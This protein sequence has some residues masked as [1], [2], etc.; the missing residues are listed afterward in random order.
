MT[1]VPLRRL[2]GEP[3]AAYA[4][5]EYKEYHE[6][7][8]SIFATLDVRPEIAVECNGAT[9]LLAA[10]ESGRGVG[11]SARGL[12]QLGGLTCETAPD[13]TDTAADD[14][15]LCLHNFKRIYCRDT[16]F[17]H[18]RSHRCG[19]SGGVACLDSG[20]ERFV[21][22]EMNSKAGPQ[23]GSQ[24]ALAPRRR[25]GGPTAGNAKVMPRPFPSLNRRTKINRN[26]LIKS[27][28]FIVCR[29]LSSTGQNSG[30]SCAMQG[31]N[32]RLPA[33]EAGALP[34]S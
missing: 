9:S 12:P 31:S 8:E 6:M 13:R 23:T 1:K 19:G 18:Q 5:A 2:L 29:C 10:V 32:L 11:H 21:R 20:F 4:R 24:F 22:F 34:L 15:G 16:A 3:L 27:H 14:R 33:C 30:E 25:S 7:L 26:P 17:P 28:L